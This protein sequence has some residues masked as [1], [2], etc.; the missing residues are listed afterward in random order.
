G[1][2]FGCGCS[3]G[4]FVAFDELADAFAGSVTVDA[5]RLTGNR[6][7]AVAGKGDGEVGRGLGQTGRAAAATCCEN[8]SRK[9]GCQP[10]SH[11]LEILHS[12]LPPSN[13]VV[14]RPARV[15]EPAPI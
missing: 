8:R 9:Q 3:Q 6:S 15:V 5:G 10:N 11:L 7:A 4:D 14:V 2:A 1:A 12:I 13:Q